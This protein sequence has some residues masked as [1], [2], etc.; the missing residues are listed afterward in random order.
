MS[1]NDFVES[2]VPCQLVKLVP[3]NQM[4]KLFLT[5]NLLTSHPLSCGQEQE[6]FIQIQINPALIE[7]R[8]VGP[9]ILLFLRFITEVNNCTQVKT[10]FFLPCLGQLIDALSLVKPFIFNLRTILIRLFKFIGQ[11]SSIL[12]WVLKQ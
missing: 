2:P 8:K 5:F 3:S 4:L 11:M 12:T 9:L 7:E 10:K 6:R 1:I